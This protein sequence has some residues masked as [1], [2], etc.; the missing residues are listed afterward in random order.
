MTAALL[1]A[2]PAVFAAGGVVAGMPVGSAKTPIMALL[3]AQ[4]A[5]YSWRTRKALA[6]HVR[7]ATPSRSRKRW[8]RLT[9]WQGS[10]DRTV[11]P[12]NAEALAAQWSELHGYGAVPTS[13]DMPAPGVRRRVGPISSG[14]IG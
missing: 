7:A 13:D 2:Y 3:Q 4:R 1:A 5:D 8:P 11:A 10:R 14:A 6:A 12:G 9:I